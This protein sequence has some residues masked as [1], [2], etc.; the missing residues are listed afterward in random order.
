[1]RLLP[2]RSTVNSRLPDQATAI[3]PSILRVSSSRVISMSSSFG[4]GD[5]SATMPLPDS[6]RLKSPSP[7]AT[8]EDRLERITALCRTVDS[9]AR[10]KPSSS[11]TWPFQSARS[12]S[13]MCL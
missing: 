8:A 10:K 6:P 9:Q 13:R 1:M 12:R 3:L 5:S 7:P 4:Q 11:T 2:E